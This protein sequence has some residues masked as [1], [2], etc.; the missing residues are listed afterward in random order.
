MGSLSLCSLPGDQ[1]QAHAA[2]HFRRPLPE[3]PEDAEQ[4]RGG[5]GEPGNY[6]HAKELRPFLPE[7]QFRE[8]AHLTRI[9]E[10]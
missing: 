4:L 3:P 7:G 10:R 9:S 6:L 2:G 5:P 8:F 1:Q